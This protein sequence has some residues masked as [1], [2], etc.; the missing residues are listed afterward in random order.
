LQYARRDAAGWTPEYVTN[1]GLEITGLSLALDGDDKA[2]IGFVLEEGANLGHAYRDDDAWHYQY[3][4]TGL[5]HPY[6]VS[7]ALDDQGRPRVALDGGSALWYGWNDGGGWQFEVAG[8]QGSDSPSL[9]LDNGGQPWISYH[10]RSSGQLVVSHKEGAAW[11]AEVALA[12]DDVYYVSGTSLAV[13]GSGRPQV[14]T[15]RRSSLKYA[16][17]DGEGWLREIVEETAAVGRFN[18]L[19]IDSQGRAHIAYYDQ[20]QGRIKYARD[21][22]G[23]WHVE[24]LPIEG[25]R[26]AFGQVSLALDGGDLPHV[27]YPEYEPASASYR[28]RYVYWN[29]LAWQ[30]ETVAGEWGQYVSLALSGTG[31][32]HVGYYVGYPDNDVKY[33]HRGGSG[34][35]VEVVH[36]HTDGPGYVSL[37]VDSLGIPHIAYSSYAYS[38]VAVSQIVYGSL[39]ASG[40]QTET[41]GT[42]G[43]GAVSLALDG[44]DAPHLAFTDYSSIYYAQRQARS[45]VVEAV[46]DGYHDVSMALDGEG[47][48]AIAYVQ[49]D[50]SYR[51]VVR[52]AQWEDAA[53]ER[54]SIHIASSWYDE[55]LSLDLDPAGSA[56]VVF[57]DRDTRD[58]IMAESLVMDHVLYL[59][60]VTRQ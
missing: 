9:A 19:E 20:S 29:G 60:L 3:A 21:D 58:L 46:D 4:S 59:P 23:G 8:N 16:Q 39:G 1:P 50:P 49:I 28:L 15:N 48:P 57:Q 13:D 27:V 2:Q 14:V 17:N 30:G 56:V 42:G 44:S 25:E 40:W 38:P 11:Q 51:K 47:A 45:W 54:S 32:P 33:A 53:W 5:G 6:G 7:L 55:D 41:V 34:W 24:T 52:F 31:V 36:D 12:G 37:K 35:E 18:A 26:N 22:A 43:G 10:D